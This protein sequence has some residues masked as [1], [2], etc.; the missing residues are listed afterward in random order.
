M[1]LASVAK[2]PAHA[3]HVMYGVAVTTQIIA[4]VVFTPISCAQG[5][6]YLCHACVSERGCRRDPKRVPMPRAVGGVVGST[7]EP[8]GV[9]ESELNAPSSTSLGIGK[10]GEG[11]DGEVGVE[12]TPLS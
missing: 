12:D 5:P 3:A 2:F 11:G 8:R 1:P 10:V 9:E 7:H 6:E 4:T